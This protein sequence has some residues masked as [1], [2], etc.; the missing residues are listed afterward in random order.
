MH[1]HGSQPG[2][3]TLSERQL[4]VEKPRLRRRGRGRLT[5][6]KRL[7]DRHLLTACRRW[8]AGGIG[9]G[10]L[11]D[12]EIA[13][14]PGLSFKTVDD[15]IQFG[16]H[17]VLAA[18][19]VDEDGKK[20]VLGVRSGASENATVTTALLEDLVA[21]GIRPDATSAVRRRWSEGATQ[22]DTQ[23][24]GAG[25]EVA[26][27]QPQAAECRRPAERFFA[28][29]VA[30]TRLAIHPMRRE[31][32]RPASL[33]DDEH[34]RFDALGNP[35]AH[36]SRHQL[37]SPLTFVETEKNYAITESMLWMLKAHLD[38]DDDNIAEML[39]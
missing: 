7:A 36:T 1:W 26:L 25:N 11:I 28:P 5:T 19:G 6:T 12:P 29:V 22:R 13:S 35:A 8:P 2:R 39:G 20:Y 27:S 37:D 24:F 9:N 32:A 34:H 14:P 18:V 31:S 3:V 30:P 38:R 4:R 16:N 21:R 10:G 15:G 17:H 23:V 33:P